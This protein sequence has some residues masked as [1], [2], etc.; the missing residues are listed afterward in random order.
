MKTNMRIRCALKNNGLKQW[1]LA[2]MLD[3]SEG[4][5]CRKLRRELPED[6][7]EHFVSAIEHYAE[8]RAEMGTG[9]EAK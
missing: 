6:E 4:A 7:Q 8:K 9:G 3:I 2:E 5:L 1:E